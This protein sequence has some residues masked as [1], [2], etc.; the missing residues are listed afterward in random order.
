MISGSADRSCRSRPA[1]APGVSDQL[2]VGAQAQLRRLAWRSDQLPVGAQAPAPPETPGRGG[3]AAPEGLAAVAT[4]T[5]PKESE[6]RQPSPPTESPS[7]PSSV[8]SPRCCIVPVPEPAK[9]KFLDG[10]RVV[11][12]E[13]GSKV[14]LNSPRMVEASRRTGVLMQ[15]IQPL[16]V[17]DFI[18]AAKRE[19][20]KTDDQA[21]RVGTRR[22]NMH[23]LLRQGYLAEL[24]ACRAALP[25]FA[26][27]QN[28]ADE[29][30]VGKTKSFRDAQLTTNMGVEQE[31]EPAS[32]A[33]QAQEEVRK[34]TLAIAQ[35]R[36]EQQKRRLEQEELDK[37][38]ARVKVAEIRDAYFTQKQQ[39]E[40]ELRDK[41][42]RAFENNFQSTHSTTQRSSC[43]L[44][45]FV[46]ASCT[47]CIADQ[48]CRFL[49]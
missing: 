35:T 4:P 41:R 27:R 26:S 20:G 48:G 37:E 30:G 21:E 49:E 8:L 34:K 40:A 2:P 39:A 23:E 22:F 38:A 12:L 14:H 47:V 9:E 43:A 7:R 17:S 11:Q 33:I 31:E 15:Q 25:E 3:M 18:L 16:E 13:D 19:G 32:T 46:L 28:A 45:N 29:G 5:P 1:E 44:S 6:T 42:N 10:G 36:F 24:L